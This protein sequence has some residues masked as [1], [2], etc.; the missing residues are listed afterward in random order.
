VRPG[1]GK[2]APLLRRH[3]DP[4]RTLAPT[5]LRACCCGALLRGG[6]FPRAKV[7]G[8]STSLEQLITSGAYLNAV[9]TA[10]KSAWE[11]LGLTPAGRA[12]RAA[13]VSAAAERSKQLVVFGARPGGL[14]GRRRG[15]CWVQ[16][17][18]SR[19]QGAGSREQ[20]AGSREQGAGS[21]EQGAGSRGEVY[22]AHVHDAFA[23][24]HTTK[25]L[26]LTPVHPTPPHRTQD[27][28]ETL[29]SNVL[30]APKA[31]ASGMR[32]LMSADYQTP[33]NAPPL[34][35]MLELY[36]VILVAGVAAN[37]AC[38]RLRSGSNQDARSSQSRHI[39]SR[40]GGP[41][42]RHER[43]RHEQLLAHPLA[44]RLLCLCLTLA[45][46]RC[47]CPGRLRRRPPD[48][49]HHRPQGAP[50]CG[51]RPRAPPL[52]AGRGCFVK[53]RPAFGCHASYGAHT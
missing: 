37:A 17:A 31:L 13:N 23:S 34:K 9:A 1:R 43:R 14:Q 7:R 45:L 41:S 11:P 24:S 28:D 4:V 5:T 8:C 29:L 51:C 20:G 52:R 26:H 32:R 19:E 33:T 40:C 38:S 27:I 39:C 2:W 50:A 10:A 16:G 42:R 18:G 21:R 36:Q 25:W 44:C 6:N 30:L 15:G 48:C 35:P 12:A 49:T 46:P 3:P 53:P 47:P 22:R